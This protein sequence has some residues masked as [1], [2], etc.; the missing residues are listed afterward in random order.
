MFLA[1]IEYIALLHRKFTFI[2]MIYLDWHNRKVSIDRVNE[3]LDN[4]IESNAGDSL[5]SNINAIE[6]KN[7]TFGYN[8]NEVLKDVSFSIKQGEKVA[9]VG[10]SGAG[11]T[12]ITGL[13]LKF[14]EPQKGKILINDK[15]I[16]DIK[17]SDIR[18]NIGIVQQDILLFDETLRYNLTLGVNDFDEDELMR[19]CKKVGLYDTITRLPLGL[20]TRIGRNGQ[21]LSGGQLQRIMILRTFLKKSKTMIFDEAT[22][23]LDVETEL[24]VLNLFSDVSNDTTLIV[25]SHRLDTIRNCD[26]IIV[27][28]DG[29]VKNVG[30]H[31]FLVQNCD[32]YKIMFSK[33]EGVA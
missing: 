26:R 25:I 19:L 10:V 30:S 27:L 1:I 3:I 32:L 6:F 22:S 11:K 12:T 28:N 17:Y 20:D 23:A 18:K 5:E 24:E 2:L 13:L 9:I 21:G 4:E 14:F 7:V 15:N 29:Y 31:D 33:S 8:D 16:I